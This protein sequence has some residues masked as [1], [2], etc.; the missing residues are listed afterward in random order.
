VASLVRPSLARRRLVSNVLAT[1]AL[2]AGLVVVFLPFVWLLSTAFKNQV[3][4]FALPPRLVFQ[5]T[6]DNFGRLLEG[7]F[8]QY[9]LNSLIVTSLATA[10]ALILGIPAG[11]G[12]AIG[13]F[14][15]R[16]VLAGWLL[17]TYMAP[18]VVY[19]V[20]MFV[21][22]VRLGLINTYLGLVLGYQT[23]MLPF[24]AW[25]MRAYF[26]DFPIEL[27]EAAR[28]DGC[29]RARAF[30]EVVL[31]VSLPGV[32]TVALLVAI[33]AWSELFGAF[34]LGGSDTF[35]APIGVYGF[36]SDYSSDYG[37]LAASTLFIVVPVLLA[38]II[39]QR[40]LLKGLTAAAVKG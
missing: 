22:F 28:I 5:P 36:L 27:E 35:T 2:V 18:A 30:L 21:I 17:V 11:Y 38:T 12:L 14:R 9:G 40:G 6:L 16:H 37:A 20:P 19:I 8:A 1:V 23:G 25:L 33:A 34:I 26:A 32:T 4:A 24:A 31:P 3:D 39:A 15:G 29:T 7:Q 10:V 13:R